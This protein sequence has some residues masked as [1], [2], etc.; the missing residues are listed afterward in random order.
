[1]QNR[2]PFG[3]YFLVGACRRLTLR[4]STELNI[5][6][7]HNIT[8]RERTVDNARRADLEYFQPPPVHNFSFGSYQ[9]LLG[10]GIIRRFVSALTEN[11]RGA[12]VP[13]DVSNSVQ[14]VDF[15]DPGLGYLGH[16]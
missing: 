3:R 15:C 14:S 6:L 2:P 4:L 8:P 5:S 10:F 13:S 11:V 16:K 12:C 9:L 7:S 1:M